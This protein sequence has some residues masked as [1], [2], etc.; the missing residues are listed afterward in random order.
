MTNP[1]QLFE[2]YVDISSSFFLF[3]IYTEISVRNIFHTSD[4][5]VNFSTLRFILS[6]WKRRRNNMCLHLSCDEPQA[7]TLTL[8][9]WRLEI[10]CNKKKVSYIDLLFFSFFFPLYSSQSITL[11]NLLPF[12]CQ[13][14]VT[15]VRSETRRSTTTKSSVFSWQHV[16][17]T[18]KSHPMLLRWSL[19]ST[20]PPPELVFL[21]RCVDLFDDVANL[22]SI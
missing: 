13:V 16:T 15:C 3:L 2:M 22:C 21:G 19:K 7:L 11:G 8:I 1:C 12:L 9:A 20:L 5:A 17:P 6:D 14:L 18:Q 10:D 4:N